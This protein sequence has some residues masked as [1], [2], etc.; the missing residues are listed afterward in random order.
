MA[1]VQAARGAV[2]QCGAA[3]AAPAGGCL[4]PAASF[5]LRGDRRAERQV[6]D[7]GEGWQGGALQAALRHGS[8]LCCLRWRF[9]AECGI[10][11]RSVV[12]S[13]GKRARSPGLRVGS[14]RGHRGA[15]HSCLAGSSIELETSREACAA[16]QRC[17]LSSPAQRERGAAHSGAGSQTHVAWLPPMDFIQQYQLIQYI[18][19]A[20]PNAGNREP[21]V[22]EGAR[23]WPPTLPPP[24]RVRLGQTAPQCGT[25][26]KW[27]P[28]QPG[29]PASSCSAMAAGGDSRA[30]GRV[31]G[32]GQLCLTA[33]LRWL[34]GGAAPA[35]M[36]ALSSPPAH[37]ISAARCRMLPRI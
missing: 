3:R 32:A 15:A 35:P 29:C 5:T 34:C 16:Q 18:T 6:Q 9:M 31:V 11:T 13:S 14:Q 19:T 33:R 36:P 21:L 7:C 26:P 37:R 22:T 12:R 25:A 30:G 1:Q 23:A 24:A 4:G 2:A 17:R 28:A 27:R 8:L 20:V 10:A